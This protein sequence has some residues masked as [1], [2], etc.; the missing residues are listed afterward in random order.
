MNYIKKLS[1]EISVYDYIR[2]SNSTRR[3]A[4]IQSY[5]Y[6]IA[7]Y[8]NILREYGSKLRDNKI[9]EVVWTASD[10]IAPS[11][12][13]AIIEYS[14]NSILSFSRILETSRSSGL[15]AQEIAESVVSLLVSGRF[16]YIKTKDVYADDILNGCLKVSVEAKELGYTKRQN[17]ES[18]KEMIEAMREVMEQSIKD[19]NFQPTESFEEFIAILN[20]DDSQIDALDPDTWVKNDYV[21]EKL[22]SVK[23]GRRYNRQMFFVYGGKTTEFCNYVTE[24]V[25]YKEGGYP[26]KREEWLAKYEDGKLRR[27]TFDEAWNRKQETEDAAEE[28]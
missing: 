15:S 6:M 7:E 25:G 2:H 20:H 18:V 14:R 8:K 23:H 16:E 13:E 9:P 10:V 24:A 17:A 1:T 3:F 22:S 11:Y 27:L 26:T 21:I 12:A 28:E 4:F 19:G 5:V